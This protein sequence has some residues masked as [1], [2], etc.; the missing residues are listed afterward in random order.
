[1]KYR[2][3]GLLTNNGVYLVPSSVLSIIN[4]NVKSIRRWLDSY[5][6]ELTGSITQ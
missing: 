2:L 4:S 1:M 6:V 3:V 5:I